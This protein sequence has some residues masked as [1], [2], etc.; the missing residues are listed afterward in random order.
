MA[1]R[2]FFSFHFKRDH[3]RVGQVRNSWV[4]GLKGEASPFLDA[5]SWEEVERKGAAAVK[6]WID[7]EIDGTGVTAIL[8][9]SETAGRPYVRYEIEQSLKKGNGLLGI[10]I[11]NVKDQ[12][13]TTSTRGRNPLD[14]FTIER[15]NWMG[16]KT[17]YR[18]SSIFK[19]YDWVNDNG[20]QNIASWIEE[21]AKIAGR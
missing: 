9:G 12:N 16:T 8:I 5:A 7:K 19:T 4:V 14:D 1:R 18:A 2:V 17:S 15:T 21:A 3:W 10:Y 11:H 13:G 20:R 6:R